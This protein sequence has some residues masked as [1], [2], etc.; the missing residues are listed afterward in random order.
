MIVTQNKIGT[1]FFH[2]KEKMLVSVYKG[3]AVTS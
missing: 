3:R 2:K 1:T